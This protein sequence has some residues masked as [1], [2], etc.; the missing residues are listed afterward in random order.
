MDLNLVDLDVVKEL[1]LVIMIYCEEIWE[2]SLEV[3]T[4]TTLKT[5]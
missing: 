5:L 4:T 1:I 2:L 3:T